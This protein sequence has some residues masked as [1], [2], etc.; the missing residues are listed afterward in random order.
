[1][2]V[3]AITLERE[4][5]LAVKDKENGREARFASKMEFESH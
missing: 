3:A 1:M 4:S 2:D 5:A